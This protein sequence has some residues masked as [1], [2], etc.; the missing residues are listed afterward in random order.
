MHPCDGCNQWCNQAPTTKE[1]SINTQ[2]KAAGRAN[3]IHEIEIDSL[4]IPFY[5]RKKLDQDHV[6]YLAELIE[7]GVIVDPIQVTAADDGKFA[8]LDGRH[9]IEAHKLLDRKHIQARVMP[10][11]KNVVEE[12]SAAF[13]A[14]IGGALPPSRE[15]VEH[16]VS[17]LCAQ[18]VS[19]R[20]IAHLLPI[21]PS[22]ARKYVNMVSSRALRARM[23]QAMEAVTDGDLTIPESAKKFDIDTETLRKNLGGRKKKGQLRLSEAV[24]VI[25]RQFRSFSQ[26]NAAMFKRLF[27]DY[28]DGEVSAE[29]VDKTLDTFKKSIKQMSVSFDGWKQRFDAAKPTQA[30]LRG[31]KKG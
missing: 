15:D 20:E 7:G 5:V 3:P 4:T 23:R 17:L 27:D 8:I 2:H 30:K 24:N 9:R 16:T 19:T 10:P 13:K 11:M 29:L 6:M 1:A 22:L 25:R 28:E 21:P 26:R 12:I 14:N 31:P 18:G